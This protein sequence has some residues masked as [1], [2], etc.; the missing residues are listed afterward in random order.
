M[1]DMSQTAPVL[2]FLLRL[3]DDLLIFSSSVLSRE[4]QYGCRNDGNQMHAEIVKESVLC[5]S[6]PV[7]FG[8][9]PLGH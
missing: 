2:L 6:L 1:F 4:D 8:Q 3:D 9:R 7:Y 5:Y